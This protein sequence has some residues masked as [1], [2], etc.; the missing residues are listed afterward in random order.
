MAKAT[1]H[2]VCQ[3]CGADYL[4][5]SGLCKACDAWN[6]ISEE[7]SSDSVPLGAGARGGGKTSKRSGRG[8]VEF[9]SLDGLTA[10]LP[11]RVTGIAELDR[12]CGGGSVTCR[13]THVYPDGPAPY[14][15]WEGL[16]RRGA[17]LEMYA[18]TSRRALTPS[19]RPAAP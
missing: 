8:R 12:V 11:R 2:Y 15:T 7:T 18:E 3:E 1:A 14:F 5:W 13:F 16:G 10:D 9:L 4:Q 19:W 6:S 17:E